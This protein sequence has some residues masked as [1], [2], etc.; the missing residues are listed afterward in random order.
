MTHATTGPELYADARLGTTGGDPRRTYTHARVGRNA[1]CE[2]LS[3]GN[4][5]RGAGGRRTSQGI[6]YTVTAHEPT[7]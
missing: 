3:S 2:R 4:R 7:L 6:A 5:S 1:P